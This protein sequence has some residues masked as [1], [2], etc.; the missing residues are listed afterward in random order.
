MSLYQIT[1][2]RTTI[3]TIPPDPFITSSG[4]PSLIC[5]L[6]NPFQSMLSSSTLVRPSNSGPELAEGPA[7][8]SK[9]ACESQLSRMNIRPLSSALA[10][11][12]Y[13]GPAAVRNMAVQ[14]Q[15]EDARHLCFQPVSKVCFI[16]YLLSFSQRDN[17]LDFFCSL[18]RT[19]TMAPLMTPRT[20][21][22]RIQ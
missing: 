14:Y 5:S 18:Y 17:Q 11:R 19:P 13:P 2:V 20:S 22:W 9:Y 4:D 6:E 8:L 16:T 7:A 21:C 10:R 15:G 3:L 1:D 12:P